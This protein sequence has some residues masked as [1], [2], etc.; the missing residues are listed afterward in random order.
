MK[1]I[2]C[3]ENTLG[4]TLIFLNAAS[5]SCDAT[6]LWNSCL[7]SRLFDY[8]LILGDVRLVSAN[9]EYP[10]RVIPKEDVQHVLDFRGVVIRALGKDRPIRGVL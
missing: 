1:I 8:P 4:D 2:M 10:E 7:W 5:A 3:N 6:R 9:K